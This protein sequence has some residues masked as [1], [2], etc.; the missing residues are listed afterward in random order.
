M[1]QLADWAEGA[2]TE[3]KREVVSLG[4]TLGNLISVLDRAMASFKEI[5]QEAKK[6]AARVVLGVP[7]SLASLEFAVA[8]SLRCS[9]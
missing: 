7:P 1:A 8:V 6:E 5:L 9:R 4:R 2:G 3:E